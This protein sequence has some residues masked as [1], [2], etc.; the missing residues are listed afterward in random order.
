MSFEDLSL[1]RV[2]DSFY[3]E[4]ILFPLNQDCLQFQR[5]IVYTWTALP[6]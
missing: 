5:Q 6:L 3:L 1:N 2:E 4:T